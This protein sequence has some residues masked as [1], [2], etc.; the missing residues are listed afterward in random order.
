[1]TSS[2]YSSTRFGVAVGLGEGV[3]F[4][5]VVGII[6]GFAVGLVE[7]LDKSISYTL[8]HKSKL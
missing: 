7:V 8:L 1:M 2:G 5:F 3:T 6:V 4:V